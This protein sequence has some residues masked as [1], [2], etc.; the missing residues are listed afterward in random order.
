MGAVTHI[1]CP[2]HLPTFRRSPPPHRA[3]PCAPPRCLSLLLHLAPF[4]SYSR[5]APALCFPRAASSPA[6]LPCAPISPISQ[7]SDRRCPPCSIAPHR[8]HILHSRPRFP[9]SPVP[10]LSASTPFVA[11]LVALVSS[12]CGHSSP[13]LLFP[14]SYPKCASPLPPAG[15]RAPPA[16]TP[17]PPAPRP[18]KASA[19]HPYTAI[20]GFNASH[21]SCV[22]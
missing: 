19:V 6:L 1:A 4:S 15:F 13:R 17:Q 9:S 2:L 16:P 5:L 22:G 21:P 11:P 3:S 10:L 12:C 7:S 8:P 20:R 14:L 18:S